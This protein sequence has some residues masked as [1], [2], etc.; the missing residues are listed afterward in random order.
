MQYAAYRCT[1]IGPHDAME[2]LAKFMLVAWT[3]YTY[4]LFGFGQPLLGLTQ[5]IFEPS[6][7]QKGL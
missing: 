7:H 6:D 4:L 1:V 5:Q 3:S 2:V